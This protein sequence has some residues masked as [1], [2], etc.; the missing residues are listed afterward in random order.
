[1]SYL[2][3][4]GRT[5]YYPVISGITRIRSA[6]RLHTR[7]TVLMHISYETPPLCA[8]G[9][10]DLGGALGV[11]RTLPSPSLSHHILADTAP[12]LQTHWRGVREAKP[13]RNTRHSMHGAQLTGRSAPDHADFTY[14]VHSAHAHLL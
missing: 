14:Y 1:M 9:T 4:P 13:E 7:F 3:L 5:R 2:V 8:R 12:Q 10:Y 6:I 11:M